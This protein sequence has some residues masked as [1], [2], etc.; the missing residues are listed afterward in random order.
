[1]IAADAGEAVLEDAAGEKL[2]GDLRDDGPPRAVLAREAVV[3]D[4][5]ESMQMI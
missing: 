2:V 1:G 5:L 4:R 3:V